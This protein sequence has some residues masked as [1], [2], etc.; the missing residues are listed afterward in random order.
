MIDVETAPCCLVTGKLCRKRQGAKFSMPLWSGQPRATPKEAKGESNES[1][2]FDSFFYDSESTMYPPETPWKDINQS[3]D[4]NKQYSLDYFMA[5]TS[6]VSLVDSGLD[7]SDS[8]T[9]YPAEIPEC[10]SPLDGTSSMLAE[11]NFHG[12]LR[13]FEDDGAGRQEMDTAGAKFI[14]WLL[15]L[16]V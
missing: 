2:S 16:E 10:E 11:I 1:A 14:N 3:V 15:F 4:G 5:P 13:C 8:S 12:T 9:L 7:E 6:K